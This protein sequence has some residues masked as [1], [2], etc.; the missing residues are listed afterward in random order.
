MSIFA[1]LRRSVSPLALVVALALPGAAL[2]QGAAGRTAAFDIPAQP[3]MGALAEFTA[4][5]GIQVISP[6]ARR[7]E[8]T[9]NPVSGVLSPEAALAQALAGSGYGFSFTGPQ[10]VLLTPAPGP[11]AEAEAEG[12]L[13][14]G[15]I[16]VTRAAGSDTPGASQVVIGASDIERLAP[17]DVADL[18]RITPSVSVGGSIPM[19]QKLYVN[20]VEET[21]LAVTIDGARQNNRVFHHNATNVIDPAL[22]RQ[23]RVEAGVA[24]AD[25]GPGAMGGAVT[26]ETVD[27]RDLLDGVDGFGARSSNTFDFNGDTATSGLTLFGLRDGLEGL[28]YLNM[29]KGGDYEDGAGRTVAG[30]ETDFISGLAKGAYETSEGH[31]L[32]LGYERVA[33][34]ADRPFRAN[35]GSIGRDEGLRSYDLVRQNVVLTYTD[36]TPEGWLDPKVVIGYAKTELDNLEWVTVPGSS[37]GETDSWSGRVENRFIL[38]MGEM[39]AG[40]DAYRDTADYSDPDYSTRERA[41][42]VGLYAQARLEPMDRVRLGLGARYD[43]HDL[44]GIGGQSFEDSGLSGNIGGEVDLTDALILRAA[45]SHVWAGPALAENFIT[46]PAWDYGDGLKPMEADN[47]TAGLVYSHGDF[48]FEANYF[49]TKIDDVRT[50]TWT[51]GALTRDLK[52]DGFELAAGYAWETGRVRLGYTDTD[53]EIDDVVADSYFGNYLGVPAGQALVVDVTQ[54]FP[55]RGITIGADAEFTFENDD[56]QATDGLSLPS[57]QVVNVFAEYVP[58]TLP[59]VTLRVEVRNLF[60]KEYSDRSTYGQDWAEVDPVREPGRSIILGAIARF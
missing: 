50:A 51:D 59:T 3:L 44:D 22:L 29:G 52:T 26:F 42:N 14:L 12:S 16:L 11:V 35:I 18:F 48:L 21:N 32:E 7:I 17:R 9:S 13:L 40:L 6:G 31:R 57:Y 45:Y 28:A 58:P 55:A 19:A 33:D 46:N 24:P 41:T 53:V 37:S 4:T 8:G 47:V 38:G 49:R 30:S 1:S 20:G 43:F 36:E 27:A 54:S 2:A 23:V 15:P 25:A 5:T 34:E 60:D 56:T 39:V 10:T